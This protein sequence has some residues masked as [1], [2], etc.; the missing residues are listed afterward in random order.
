MAGQQVLP[1]GPDQ[2]R[3]HDHPAF[4]RYAKDFQEKY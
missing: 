4:A 2:L 1:G 3:T